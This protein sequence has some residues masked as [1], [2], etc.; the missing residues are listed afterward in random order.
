MGKQENFPAEFFLP[1][2]KVIFKLAHQLDNI[3]LVIELAS[4][5]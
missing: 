2:S 5:V 3:L 1:D 4:S